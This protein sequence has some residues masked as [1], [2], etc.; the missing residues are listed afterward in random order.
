MA[1]SSS[2]DAFLTGDEAILDR[3]KRRFHACEEWEGPARANA[4]Y[5]YKFA[6]ADSVNNYQ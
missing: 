5:D 2:P 3:A 1:Y 6:H 4:E